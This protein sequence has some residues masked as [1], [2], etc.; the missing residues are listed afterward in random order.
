MKEIDGIKVNP[1]L[2]K[3]FDTTPNEKRSKEEIDEWWQVPFI[4]NRGDGYVVRCLDG[5]A[6]DR[7]TLKGVFDTLE[8]AVQVAKDIN[9]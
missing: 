7:A 1:N 2:P 8:E 9:S 4:E 6:W 3:D 5:G